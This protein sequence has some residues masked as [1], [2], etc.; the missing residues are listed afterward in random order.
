MGSYGHNNMSIRTDNYF[1]YVKKFKKLNKHNYAER[2]RSKQKEGE[3]SRELRFN[4]PKSG[5]ASP[6]H[7]ANLSGL[8][9]GCIETEFCKSNLFWLLLSLL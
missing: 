8:V 4:D 6:N 5:L 2:C 9:L 1:A 3:S 7:T